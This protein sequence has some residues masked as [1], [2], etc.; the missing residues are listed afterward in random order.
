MTTQ[1]AVTSKPMGKPRTH[2]I[3]WERL[4]VVLL[5]CTILALWWA[6][7]AKYTID[8]LPLLL[9]EVAAFFRAPVQL[10]QVTDWRWYILMAW[11][12]I[13]ISIAERRYAPWRRLT[14][15]SIMIWVIGVWLIVSGI[16]AGSTWL[17]V[18]HPPDDAY[19]ITKQIAAIKPL[20]AAWSVATT[21]AP[22]IGFGALLWWLRGR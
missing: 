22:E 16:D 1:P 14:L 5:G 2:L 3:H 18:T 4:P 15:S 17:A 19:T 6:T 8:G 11:L 21:F 10:G 7:G 13:T 9:N 20:A 12:P